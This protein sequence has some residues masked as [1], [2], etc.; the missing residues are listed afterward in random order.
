M[1]KN[2]DWSVNF[3]TPFPH[4][5]VVILTG[6]GAR[7]SSIA[8]LNPVKTPLRAS[9]NARFAPRKFIM[10]SGAHFFVHMFSCCRWLISGR[11]QT[12]IICDPCSCRLLHYNGQW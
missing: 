1:P 11:F 9:F 6:V 5:N 4:D 8:Q 12:L 7:K 3:E 10:L 2:G